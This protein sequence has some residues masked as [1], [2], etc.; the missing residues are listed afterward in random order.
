MAADDTAD[1][2]T[3]SHKLPGDAETR[4]MEAGIRSG[5]RLGVY[6]LLEQIGEGGFGSVYLAEQTEPVRRRVAIKLLKMGSETEHIVARFEAERQTLALMD[7]PNIAMILDAGQSG[8]GRPYFVM[9]YVQ[10]S[11]ISSFCD[12]SSI[13]IRGRIELMRGVCH[14]VQHAHQKGIIHRDIKPNNVLVTIKDDVP[15]PKVIDFGIAKVTAGTSTDENVYTKIHQ[16]LG[17]P[18]YMSPEQ[19]GG[20]SQGVDTRA[21]VFSIGAMLYELLVGTT[22][23]DN[24]R[25]SKLQILDLHNAIATQSAPSLFDRFE[26]LADRRTEIAAARSTT[27][28]S[29]RQTTRGDLNWIVQRCLEKDPARRYPSVAALDEDLRRYLQ[30]EPVS[31]GPPSRVYLLKKFVR[32]HRLEVAGGCVLAA[33]LSLGFAG[34]VIGWARAAEESARLQFTL[35]FFSESLAGATSSSGPIAIW[36]E[37]PDLTLGEALAGSQ[38]LIHDN[39]EQEPEL[40]ATIRQLIG[41]AQLRSGKYDDAQLQ[42]ARA[43]EIRSERLDIDDPRALE[44]LLPIA[45]AR[46]KAGDIEGATEAAKNAYVR[47]ADVFG[48][49]S[50]ITRSVAFWIAKW[51]SSGFKF[52]DAETYFELAALNVGGSADTVDSITLASAIERVAANISNGELAKAEST[53][54]STEPL[55]GRLQESE[56]TLLQLFTRQIGLVLVLQGNAEE[57]IEY[58]TPPKS[59]ERQ[60]VDK[61]RSRLLAWAHGKAGDAELADQLFTN[62]LDDERNN[63]GSPFREIFARLFYADVLISQARPEEAARQASL[64]IEKY[65]ALGFPNDPDRLWGRA[66]AATAYIDLGREDEAEWA[67]NEATQ[68]F[69]LFPEH[70]LH[71][72]MILWA[73]AK[74]AALKGDT[75][76]AKQLVQTAIGESLDIF[77]ADHETTTAMQLWRDSN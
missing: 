70:K 44:L 20:A 13:N 53:L 69:I 14:A 26:G 76:T 63:P 22:P 29:L 40:E 54:R 45:E 57:A 56:S 24:D 36:S 33:A 17:T 65:D 61:V 74:L 68:M 48:K 34:T 43:Y 55:I 52:A 3:G 73:Q 28:A 30:N 51:F 15:V 10:G 66:L 23:L 4:S 39:F 50:E 75:D 21:D 38:A 60:A 64:A 35:D 72:P 7:H 41:L 1:L 46:S 37:N 62:L 49:E 16:M 19:A 12:I 6:K 25:I 31:A 32:R 2:N 42:L 67:L 59:E 9:E 77:G 18:A 27:V 71:V 47:H 5:D 11:P 8:T 58:L